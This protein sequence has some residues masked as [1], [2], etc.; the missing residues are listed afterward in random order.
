MTVA[1]GARRTTKRLQ[2]REYLGH[3]WNGALVTFPLRFA[4]GRCVTGSFRLVD[5]AGVERPVQV[6][7]SQTHPDGS[8]AA[9]EAVFAADVPAFGAT[10]YRLSCGPVARPDP[11][12]RTDLQVDLCDQDG[13]C[14]ATAAAA[15][16]VARGEGQYPGGRPLSELP[17][18][19][20]SVRG[21]DGCW[22]GRGELRGGPLVAAFRSE[23]VASGPLVAEVA[24]TY[25]FVGGGW[26]RVR[27]RVPAAD[28]VLL[29]REEYANARDAHFALSLV[30]GFAPDTGYW[31]VHTGSEDVGIPFGR[32]DY[33]ARRVLYVQPFNEW[34]SSHRFWWG[35]FTEQGSTRDFVGVFTY[36]AAEWR[37]RKPNRIQIVAD[38]GPTLEVD[39]PINDG[40]RCWGMLVGDKA[41]C[42]A[43]GP[44]HPHP[45]CRATIRYGDFPLDR[46]R[47]YVLSWKRPQLPRPRLLVQAAEVGAVRRRAREHPV[48]MELLAQHEGKPRGTGGYWPADERDPAGAYLITGEQRFAEEAKE[49]IV[50][51]LRLFVADLLERQGFTN[52][53]IP[54]A[55][56]T[57][58]VRPLAIHYDLV[59][60][61]GVFAAAEREWA[62]AVFAFL[63]HVLTEPSCWPPASLGFNKG[64]LNFDSDYFTA[65]TAV[66]ALLD[67]H[68][69]QERWLRFVEGQV[70]EEFHRH[71]YPGGV[72]VECPNY[73]AATMYWT[74]EAIAIL[75]NIGRRDFTRSP[76]VRDALEFFARVRTPRDPRT[77]RRMLPTIG[78]THISLHSQGSQCLFGWAAHLCR[79]DAAFSSRMMHAWLEGGAPLNGPAVALAEVAAFLDPRLP[80]VAPVPLESE[81]LPGLGAVFRNGYGTPAESYCFVKMGPILDHYDPDE[82]SFHWYAKGAPLCLDYGCMYDPQ[83]NQTW[84]HNRLSFDHQTDWCRGSLREFVAF[85]SADY[86]SGETVIDR[87]QEFGDSPD[88]QPEWHRQKPPMAVPPIVWGRQMIFVKGPDLLVVADRARTDIPAQWSLHCLARGVQAEGDRALFAG[89]FGVDL[90]VVMARPLAPSFTT[91]SWGHAGKLGY[92]PKGLWFSSRPEGAVP[93]TQHYLRVSAPAEEGYLAL[94][95][96]RPQGQDPATVVPLADRRGFEVQANDTLRW[97]WLSPETLDCCT[98]SLVFRGRAGV[99][100]QTPHLTEFAV[101]DGTLAAAGPYGVEG[102]GPFRVCF[103][104]DGVEGQCT[105]R[106]TRLILRWP[107]QGGRHRLTLDGRRARAAR[108]LDDR[109]ALDLPEGAHRFRMQVG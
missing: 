103:T 67:G 15:F 102:R 6:R 101:F 84:F 57:R 64:N 58:V 70:E 35:A 10:A 8:L 4:Q 48:L 87:L 36:E 50:A 45:L 52:F 40:A 5:E 32:I 73:Q 12:P 16:R 19:V 66:V 54:A 34:E 47:R 97:I 24:V 68:P 93:E 3:A 108:L 71:A 56:M 109:L 13:I 30:P 79:Q 62:E 51:A 22:R 99:I 21:P 28:Q 77:D 17:A 46:V 89:Q 23:V 20:L 55:L 72:W 86:L 33:Q 105:G 11:M 96:P 31:W 44:D 14:I 94:L 80:A 38:R 29:V 43:A 27:L 49:R 7:A 9:A 26:Y 53:N 107:G 104:A 78:D 81:E 69:H 92:F 59:V 100:T 63:A 74:L 95:Y 76:K 37:N 42:T 2:I 1:P 60:P 88:A 90:Q 41:D 25:G 75:R 61:S 82:G 106:G 39:C 65:L 85:A 83:N 98:D 18:P 91:G